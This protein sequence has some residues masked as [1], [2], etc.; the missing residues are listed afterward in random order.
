MR[1]EIEFSLQTGRVTLFA[2]FSHVELSAS[3]IEAGKLTAILEQIALAEA[4]TDVER[5]VRNYDLQLALKELAAKWGE[6]TTWSPSG[7]GQMRVRKFRENGW[8]KPP[9]LEEI[10]L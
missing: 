4:A 1:L 5:A 9:T 3:Q 10:G 2:P 7:C 6:G 8:E